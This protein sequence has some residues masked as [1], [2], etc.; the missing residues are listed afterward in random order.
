M[1]VKNGSIFSEI[2]NFLRICQ[3]LNLNIN[4]S[5]FYPFCKVHCNALMHCKMLFDDIYK[6]TPWLDIVYF[7]K[8]KLWRIYNHIAQKLTQ[9]WAY[10]LKKMR[11]K[12]FHLILL[13]LF[14]TLNPSNILQF[15]QKS[16]KKNTFLTDD[17]N[18]YLILEEV[19]SYTKGGMISSFPVQGPADRSLN[20]IP[21]E[22]HVSDMD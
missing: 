7:T 22:T 3:N 20:R 14:S 13:C 18:I 2:Q 17:T 21:Q 5:F 11:F 1:V 8:L 15:L 10:I 6:S 16:F 19:I 12:C 4:L 9:V